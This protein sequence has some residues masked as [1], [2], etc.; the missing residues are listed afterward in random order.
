MAKSR[1]SADKPPDKVA[2]DATQPVAAPEKQRPAAEIRRGRV[3]AVVWRNETEAG[4]RFNVNLRRIFKRDGSSVWEESDSFSRD[5]LPLV[6]QVAHE[7]W[8][9]IY[10]HANS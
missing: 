10:E 7:A 4:V 3:K 9:W 2:V 5:D 6:E 1:P 8:L